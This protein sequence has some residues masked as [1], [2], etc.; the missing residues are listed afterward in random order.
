MDAIQRDLEAC[1]K[2]NAELKERAKNMSKKALLMVWYSIFTSLKTQYVKICVYG[3][4]AMPSLFV[5]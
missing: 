1:E 3:I 5:F 2:E 4:L